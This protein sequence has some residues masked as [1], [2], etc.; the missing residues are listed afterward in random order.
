M[1]RDQLYNYLH[2][3]CIEFGFDDIIKFEK[4]VL[5]NYDIKISLEDNQVVTTFTN[6]L[7]NHDSYFDISNDFFTYSLYISLNDN[8]GG[9]IL[10]RIDSSF[11]RL[12]KCEN[13]YIYLR[14]K[15]IKTLLN[16]KNEK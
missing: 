5:G 14:Y 1:E 9:I 16:N 11:K 7:N 4:Y 2:E 3:K 8:F 10:K 12:K 15:K 6:N 13:Y